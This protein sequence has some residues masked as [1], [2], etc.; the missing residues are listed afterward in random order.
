[1]PAGVKSRTVASSLTNPTLISPERFLNRQIFMKRI[2]GFA[3]KKG[4]RGLQRSFAL[5]P[6][7]LLLQ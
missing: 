4:K 2:F 3:A 6:R 5:S 7:P 1:M